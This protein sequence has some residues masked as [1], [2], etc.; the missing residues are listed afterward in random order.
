MALSRSPA[1][2][3]LRTSG[4]AGI[5]DIFLSP[6]TTEEASS[7]SVDMEEHTADSLQRVSDDSEDYSQLDVSSL[8]FA[9]G[10]SS[11]FAVMPAY[12]QEQ[13]KQE[14][15]ELEDLRRCSVP[16]YHSKQLSLLASR[17][18]GEMLV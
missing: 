16:F 11:E 8:D 17:P 9:D 5:D 14:T 15:A 2:R 10:S 12:V 13:L 4:T 1:V 7:S 3:R 6:L 18:A